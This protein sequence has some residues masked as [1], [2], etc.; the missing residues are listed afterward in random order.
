MDFLLNVAQFGAKTFIIVIAI[1]FILLLAAVLVARAKASKD[2]LI[3]DLN[4]K[5]DQI[6]NT[7]KRQTWPAKLWKKEAKKKRKARK[8]TPDKRAYVL[9]FEGDIRATHVER[10]RDEITSILTVARPGTDE[11]ILK[12]ESPGGMVHSYGLA[13]AQLLRLRDRGI[14]LTICVDKV[15]ASG[16]YLMACTGHRIVAAP[17]AILGSIGVL[18]QVPNVHRLLKKNDIDY[19]EVTAG[20]YK[21]TVTMFGEVTEKGREKFRQKIE[22]TH[23]LFKNFV[24]EYRPQLKLEDV[25]NG[26]YW[27]GRQA[28]DLGLIDQMLSSDDYIFTLKDSAKIYRIECLAK[29]RLSEKLAENFGSMLEKTLLRVWGKVSETRF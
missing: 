20:E 5:L 7:I 27:Y 29:K 1:A 15:A 16:G 25:A 22:D 4:D 3:E 14:Q 26:D 17:F 11:V 9:T 18:A 10:L 13:A 19:E 12:L 6:E 8:K 24:K 2:L 21:R 23:G 28:L